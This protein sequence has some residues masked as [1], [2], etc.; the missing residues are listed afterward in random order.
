[1]KYLKSDNT[2]ITPNGFG[3]KTATRN[4]LLKKVKAPTITNTAFGCGNTTVQICATDY[5]EANN[6]NWSVTNGTIV[7]GQGTPCIYVSTTT[8]ALPT[9]TCIVKRNEGLSNY[10]ATTT[11]TIP[12]SS[13]ANVVSISGPSS[14]C[15]SATYSINPSG[16]GTVTNWNIQGSSLATLSTTS[17]N[18]VTLTKVNNGIILLTATISNSCGEIYNLPAKTIYVGKLDSPA[19]MSGP[20]TVSPGSL[21]NYSASSVAGATSYTWWLPYPYDTV[22]TFDYFAQNWAKTISGSDG[23]SIQAFTGYAGTSGLVQVMAVNACGRGGAKSLSVTGRSGSGGIYPR[24]SNLIKNLETKI[25]PN[26]ANNV[27]NIKINADVLNTKIMAT[28]YDMVGRQ[29]L[30]VEVLDSVAALNVE[31]IPSGNYILKLNYNSELETHQII[32]E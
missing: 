19:S 10:T 32:I 21:V 29:I 24:L 27:M 28:L 23:N 22:T 16:L 26:P 12:R 15:S 2:D 5:D 11:K 20:T 1:M 8:T 18:S 31:E 14:L 7:S 9:A 17:G 30:Q 13:F 4:V 25:Y 6:F 3:T